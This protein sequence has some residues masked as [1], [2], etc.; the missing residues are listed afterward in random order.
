M[1]RRRYQNGCIRKRG[2]RNPV[3]E[4]LWWEDFI[5][6]D[7]SLGRRLASKTLGPV[8]DF[9]SD[10][11]AERRNRCGRVQRDGLGHGPTLFLL[12]G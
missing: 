9:I 12:P 3:W 8:R 11:E 6:E 2:K 1:A 7:G 10:L 4:L 5:R